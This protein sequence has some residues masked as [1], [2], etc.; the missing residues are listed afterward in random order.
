MHL[1]RLKA[2]SAKACALP[3][4]IHARMYVPSTDGRY[5]LSRVQEDTVHTAPWIGVGGGYDPCYSARF[6]RKQPEIFAHE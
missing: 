2:H 3:G 6:F 1:V 5:E 4:M